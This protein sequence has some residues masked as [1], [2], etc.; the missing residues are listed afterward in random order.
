MCAESDFE[1][2]G[3]K[4]Q[5]YGGFYGA[6]FSRTVTNI[7]G[8]FSTI[9]YYARKRGGRDSRDFDILKKELNQYNKEELIRGFYD[10]LENFEEH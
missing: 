4:Y 5:V 9:D 6:F 2:R 10:M 7:D 1:I 3:V 8:N